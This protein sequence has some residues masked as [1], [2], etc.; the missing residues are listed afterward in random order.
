MSRI[1]ENMQYQTK[2]IFADTLDELLKNNHFSNITVSDII[3]ASRV[4]R[5]TFYRHFKDKYDLVQWMYKNKLEEL[6]ACNKGDDSWRKITEEIYVYLLEKKFFFSKVI[7]FDTQNSLLEYIYELTIHDLGQR[8]MEKTNQSVLSKDDS[9]ALKLYSAG[10]IH[11]IRGW[12]ESGMKEDP[13]D[14]AR[15]VC[16]SM[17]NCLV[18]YF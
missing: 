11:I 1:H 2:L 13:K 15:R 3:T 9:L 17:P 4:S 5:A 7:P 16:D 8:I 6:L 14:M 10:I 18:K 12:V